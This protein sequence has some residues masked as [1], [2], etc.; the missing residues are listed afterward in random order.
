MSVLVPGQEALRRR[1]CIGEHAQQLKTWFA[2]VQAN[3]WAYVNASTQKR[4]QKIFL[5]TE[6]PL[7]T[8]YAISH[9]H[10]R[11]ITCEVSVEANAEIPAFLKAD[12]LTGY[13]LG[14]VSVSTGF[15]R[16][17]TMSED[18]SLHSL[19]FKVCEAP[20]ITILG[21]APIEKLV[22]VHAY[23]SVLP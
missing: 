13:T 8:A 1:A 19:F 17:R 23:M 3:A 18:N 16:V 10:K 9:E 14:R 4:P 6:Q 21:K 11:S 7:A 12:V 5:V 2:A 20:P 15:Q 22:Q